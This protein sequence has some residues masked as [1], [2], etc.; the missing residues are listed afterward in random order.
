MLAALPGSALAVRL[1]AYAL[2]VL[3]GVLGAVMIRAHPAAGLG[4]L[5]A[6]LALTC[7]DLRLPIRPGGRAG[8]RVA[9][10]LLAG[11]AIIALVALVP[12]MFAPTFPDGSGPGSVM[13]PYL[14]RRACS[15]W[16]L[17][18]ILARPEAGPLRTAAGRRAGH[19]HP[20]GCC[21][22]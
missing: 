5:L 6:G 19:H 14:R 21:P 2:A 20:P 12:R 10:P 9:D 1:P 11:A 13:S 22:P 18:A 3:A 4:T 8:F 15:P 16:P 7:I 17:G